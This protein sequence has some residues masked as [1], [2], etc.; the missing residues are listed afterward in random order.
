MSPRNPLVRFIPSIALVSIIVGAPF[1]RAQADPP[2]AFDEALSLAVDRSRQP[3]AQGFAAESARAMAQAAGE[4]PDPMLRFGVNNVPAAGEDRFSLT[5]DF[6]TMRSV[7]LA[8][9]LTR[10]AKRRARTERFER[11]AESA[12]ASRALAVAT[13]RRET[14]LAWLDRHYEEASRAVLAR[15]RDEARLAITAA[16]TAYRSNRGML[17][18]VYAARAAVATLDDRLAEMDRR[19]ATATALL[20][21]WVGPAANRPLGPPPDLAA[22]PNGTTASPSTLARHPELAALERKARAAEAEVAL[23]RES[24]QP[25]WTVELMYS[26]RG[27]SFPNMFSL[28][29]SLPLPWDRANRQDREIAAK[30]AAVEQVRAEREEMLRQREADLAS[31]ESARRNTIGRLGRY[32]AEIAPL[33]EERLAAALAA[34]RGGGGTLAAVLEARRGVLEVTMDRLRLEREAAQLAAQLAFL[35]TTLPGEAP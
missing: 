11:E 9:E 20:A 31:A 3:A 30:R 35:A 24:R 23:A 33:A 34:Y 28:N 4:L 2:L 19:V 29:V 5:R 27:P 8:Q 21:R 16:D 13:V 26:Q 12:D 6:M 17:T 1:A 18:E 14:A 25:D 15:Q 10:G 32:R 22:S 7:S